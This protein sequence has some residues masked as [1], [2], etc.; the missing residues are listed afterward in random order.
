MTKIG[1]R[2]SFITN[3]FMKMR[4]IYIG[5][6]FNDVTRV[7]LGYNWLATDVVRPLQLDGVGVQNN[8]GELKMRYLSP[9]M[10][11]TFLRKRRYNFSIPVQVGLGNAFFKYR[12][13]EGKK[14]TTDPVTV[15]FYEPALTGEYIVLR[16]IGLGAGVGYR[17]MFIGGKHLDD[18]FNAPVYMIKFKLYFGKLFR[19]IKEGLE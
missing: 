10:E 2:N 4:G 1:T 12:D 9:Y 16:F 18:N 13:L 11:Y 17:L 19:E 6:N 5:L 7:G 3:S 8:E 15:A 14:Q